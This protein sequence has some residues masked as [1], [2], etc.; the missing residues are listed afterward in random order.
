MKG[1]RIEIN[2]GEVASLKTAKPQ[3]VKFKTAKVSEIAQ[4]FETAK[5]QN[6]NLKPQKVMILLITIA[7]RTFSV[8]HFAV[9][10]F[11]V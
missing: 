3:N 1:N 11:A 10:H 7:S 4:L 9:L 6:V 2:F 5:P 8:L